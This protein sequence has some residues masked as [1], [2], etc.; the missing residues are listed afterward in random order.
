M[1]GWGFSSAAQHLPGKFEV[2][3]KIPGTKK[4]RKYN[5]YTTRRKSGFLK[6]LLCVLIHLSHQI[7]FHATSASSSMSKWPWPKHFE[8][9]Q[10]TEAARTVQLKTFRS[11]D[12]SR[13]LSCP[14]WVIISVHLLR[15]VGVTA[16]NVL[17]Q[18]ILDRIRVQVWLASGGPAHTG[19]GYS[20]GLKREFSSVKQWWW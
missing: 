4:K 1:Q 9:I 13:R 6:T 16:V 17:Q 15:S 19:T 20:Q 5:E 10:D 7:C 2:L 8:S 14:H 3:S 12:P 11:R 18:T